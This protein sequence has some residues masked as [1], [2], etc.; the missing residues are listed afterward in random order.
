VTSMT[1][2][3]MR[4]SLSLCL[5]HL[6][7]AHPLLAA[8]AAPSTP[9]GGSKYKADAAVNF[10]QFGVSMFHFIRGEL[11]ST[12]PGSAPLFAAQDPASVRKD[13]DRLAARYQT[14][15]SQTN[16]LANATESIGDGAGSLMALGAVAATGGIGLPVALTIVAHK[17]A[18]H[19]AASA[20]REEGRRDASEALAHGLKAYAAKN[21]L[22]PAQVLAQVKSQN[23]DDA[24]KKFVQDI[25]VLKR[26]DEALKD[27][28]D[29]HRIAH[30]Q[31][32]ESFENVTEGLIQNAGDTWSE[33]AK[34]SRAA[35]EFADHTRASLD[36][37]EQRTTALKD[38]V[39]D[40]A[41][42]M[43]ALAKAQYETA[44]QLTTVQ[45][46]LYRNA[47]PEDKLFLL[48]AGAVR[49]LSDSQRS[50][51]KA[52]L[53]AQA[54]TRA[55]I[56]DSARMVSYAQQVSSILTNLGVNDPQLNQAVSLAAS[57]QSA[58]AAIATGD[59]L[60]G[61]NVVSAMFGASRP[62]PVQE[63]FNRVMAK[64]DAMDRKLDSIIKLQEL[65]LKS[66]EALSKQM[67]DF[68]QRVNARFERVDFELA[69][70]ADGNAVLNAVDLQKCN[71]IWPLSDPVD[72][73]GRWRFDDVPVDQQTYSSLA[74]FLNAHD[75]GYVMPCVRGLQ[76]RLDTLR[77]G[78]SV[79][80]LPLSLRL[81]WQGAGAGRV[82]GHLSQDQM[83]ALVKQHDMALA[84]L[85]SQH[86]NRDR[87]MLLSLA[88]PSRLVTAKDKQGGRGQLST[89]APDTDL[90]KLSDTQRQLIL[91]EPL[92]RDQIPYY[93]AWVARAARPYDLWNKESGF[94]TRYYTINEI[95]DARR[96]PRGPALYRSLLL[97]LDI[98]IAQ[99]AMLHGELTAAA[100]Y[101]DAW[102]PGTNLPRPLPDS[103][104]TSPAANA[105]RLLLDP[106]FNNEW[107]RRNVVMMML[108]DSEKA[109]T[110]AAASANYARTLDL[111][112]DKDVTSIDV[113]MRQIFRLNEG[114][115][116]ESKTVEGTG[117]TKLALVF[118]SEL[119]VDMP[120]AAEFRDGRLLYPEFLPFLVQLRGLF[121]AR[122]ADYEAVPT[123]PAELSRISE[124][125]MAAF[126]ERP[127]AAVRPQ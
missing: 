83:G 24:R 123:D 111:L 119:T 75:S 94:D 5:V 44:D 52:E 32:V 110:H 72:V 42:K 50:A 100:V 77:T 107:L 116:I 87:D 64:L 15:V 28:P 21:S 112:R 88:S 39:E 29:A 46:L 81:T 98:G 55:I 113:W 61:L 90:C 7:W 37:L 22:T 38:S 40:A 73:T 103:T 10:A 102:D 48:E 125:L 78:G 47:S 53:E 34:Q 92:V 71:S 41:I 66:I 26:L 6:V 33:L 95:A 14:K 109:P 114:V 56:N 62:D 74:A 86:P 19:W 105:K 59:Y 104:D 8:Q 106:S 93:A 101:K 49:G 13:M 82:A 31:I 30:A 76:A 89:C 80:G 60:G 91:R 45:E 79:V 43:D 16:H 4:A 12:E 70:I 18:T 117:M 2:R 67:A 17:Q 99:Q 115:R 84:V 57:A 63:G 120:S 51:L 3:P 23:S 68:D 108:L 97:F 20:L 9:N 25:G 58:F 121:A 96:S 1:L 127:L 54:R 65:T 85:Q 126:A 124:N 35:R 36:S 27:D 122:L 69:R 118:S 11:R